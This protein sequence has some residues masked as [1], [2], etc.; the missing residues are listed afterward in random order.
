MD[1]QAMDNYVLRD[2]SKL[3]TTSQFQPWAGQLIVFTINRLSD[4]P[5]HNDG[6]AGVRNNDP[7]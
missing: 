3:P 7:N 5:P 4:L 6:L 2:W 1:G